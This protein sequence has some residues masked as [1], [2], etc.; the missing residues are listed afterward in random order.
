MELLFEEL[1][2]K[3]ISA[4]IDV[5]K[6][7]RPGLDEKIYERAL[8]VEFAEQGI[9]FEQQ[10]KFEIH[11]KGKYLGHLI[12]D[13]VVENKIIVDTKCVESF[14][15]THDAQML[16]YLN[17]TGLDLAL[18]LNFKVWPL[19]KRRVLRPNFNKT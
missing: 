17:I 3:I 13:L 2:G 12:P 16:G 14:T 4:A 15:P 5:H 10:R 8:C 18:L 6:S 19:G 9:H 1:T 7:L 11:Y